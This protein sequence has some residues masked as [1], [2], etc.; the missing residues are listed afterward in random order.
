MSKTVKIVIAAIIGLLLVVGIIGAATYYFVSNSPKNTYLKSEQETAKQYQEYAKTRFKD[1]FEF[2]DKMKDESYLVNMDASA[3]VPAKLLKDADIPK[4]VVDGSKIGIKV[5]HDPDKDKSVLALS[6]TIADNS[7]GDFQWAADK[8]NQ[9]YEAPIL[10]DVYKA[11]ND[12][13]VDV[14]NKLNGSSSS[15]Y[16]STSSQNDAITNDSLNLNTILSSTQISEEKLEDISKRYSDL[17]VDELEDDN[18]DKEDDTIS[19]DGEDTDVQ[20]VTMT[21]SKK[22]T[23]SI[24]QT[25]L[26]EAKDD[27]D[28]KD[29]A[30]DKMQADSYEDSLDDAL[31]EVKD[32]DA[33]DFP[34]VKSVIWEDDNQILKRDLTLKA[35]N[36]EE[37]TLEGTSNIDDDNLAVDYK[38]K[39]D[40]TTLG[41]KG[42]STKKDDT[43]NDKY[44]LTADESY[45]KSNIKISNKE[46]QDGDKRTDKGNIT[47]GSEYDETTIDYNNVLNTDTKNN[48]QKQKLDVTMDVDGEPVTVTLDGDVKLKEDIKFDK[49]NAKDLNTLS[50]SDFRKLQREI[51]DNTEDIVKD[52]SKDLK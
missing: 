31:Q 12:E 22:E 51:S 25:V 13:L 40:N 29:I 35:E 39:A 6:P 48:Q 47:F 41:I 49:E 11:K 42:K 37:V 9:Y 38:I 45:K 1:G 17:I 30:E 44:T 43:Y 16:S 7:I 33:E 32:T 2:Q 19:V 18:F 3:D 50:D 28:I 14:F 15:S 4:S 5:G 24:I 8:N 34:S 23:K 46:K 26:E 27:D 52:V 10:D 21:L 20:K 36:G